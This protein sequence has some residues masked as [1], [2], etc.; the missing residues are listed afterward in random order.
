M[1]IVAPDTDWRLELELPERRVGHLMRRL[2]ETDEPVE[3][4]FALASHPNK[5]LTGQLKRVDR[6]LEVRS[7]DGNT[8]LAEIQ[9]DNSQVAADLLRSGTRVNAKL[10]CG[11]RSIGYVWFH[12][13]IETVRSAAM[14]WF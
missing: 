6:K 2:N 4:T 14:F 10:H 12:E 9:F 3:V 1:T 5:E 11:T 7:E 8:A 13:V